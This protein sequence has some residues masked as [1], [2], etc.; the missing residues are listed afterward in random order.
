MSNGAQASL[1]A[2]RRH[3]GGAHWII[4]LEERDEFTQSLTVP[5]A[6]GAES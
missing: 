1:S 3:L 2:V 6:S 4:D 5:Q